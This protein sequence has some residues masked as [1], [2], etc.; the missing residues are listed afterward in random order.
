MKSGSKIGR[1][2]FIVGATPWVVMAGLRLSRLDRRIGFAALLE[3]L[4]RPAARPL[5]RWLA[6]PRELNE[7]TERL[8]RFLPPRRYGICLRRALLLLD[9]WSRC[10][11]RPNVH[12]GF[13]ADAP[14]FAGHAWLT[15][16]DVDGATLQVS[17]P[18]DTVSAL[19]L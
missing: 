2:L 15:A 8:L 4:R 5:P 11:L 17:G 1:S 9:L 14:D 12:L 19:E 16:I 10:G 7:T 18:L 6:R 3:V 13:R